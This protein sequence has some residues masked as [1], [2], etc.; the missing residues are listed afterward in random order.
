MLT[1]AVPKHLRLHVAGCRQGGQFGGK[2][3]DKEDEQSLVSAAVGCQRER[4]ERLH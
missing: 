3:Q 2:A 4:A 1:E